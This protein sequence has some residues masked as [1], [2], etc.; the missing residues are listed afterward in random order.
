MSAPH[1]FEGEDDVRSNFERIGPPCGAG[2]IGLGTLIKA[3]RDGGYSGP[4]QG[5]GAGTE[6]MK[7][8]AEQQQKAKSE[9]QRQRRPLKVMSRAQI[10]AVPTPNRSCSRSWTQAP[11]RSSS[12]SGASTR[13]FSRS[14][15]RS[16]SRSAGAGPAARFGAPSMS[17][18][19]PAKASVASR[20]G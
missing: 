7:A 5:F 13:V 17:C 18:T 14:I 4:G 9:Q 12:A 6:E 2:D 20:N 16:T 8:K 1:N 11:S 3:A 15:R 19:S 10:F